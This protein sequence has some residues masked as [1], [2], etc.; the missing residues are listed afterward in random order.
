MKYIGWFIL[1]FVW[2]N[3]LVTLWTVWGVFGLFFS[4]L[5]APIA[6][7]MYLAFLLLN[8]FLYFFLH[9]MGLVIAFWMISE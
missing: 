6:V 4:I 3:A 7:I 5:A 8:S 1:F 2:I 9:A